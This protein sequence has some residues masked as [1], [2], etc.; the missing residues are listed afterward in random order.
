MNASE[1]ISRFRGR[2]SHMPG[3]PRRPK[4]HKGDKILPFCWSRNARWASGPMTVSHKSLSRQGR[5]LSQK[6][7]VKIPKP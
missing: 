5:S 4:Y 3:R 2:N 1:V 6:I 7:K